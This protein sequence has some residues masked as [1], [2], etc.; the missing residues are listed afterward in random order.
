M[1]ECT[2]L[3]IVS[4]FN[5]IRIYEH[6]VP[7]AVQQKFVTALRELGDVISELKK[8]VLR[9]GDDPRI[10]IVLFN[11]TLFW[12]K[13]QSMLEFYAP[14]CEAQNIQFPILEEDLTSLM[15]KVE[16]SGDKDCVKFAVA[17]FFC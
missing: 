10:L 3:L 12:S 6:N 9:S 1:A 4:F 5:G 16:T 2:V 11:T 17:N 7:L 15:K 13:V 8:K 14:R